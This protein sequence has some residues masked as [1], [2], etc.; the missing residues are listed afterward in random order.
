[1]AALGA[2]LCATPAF[3][4]SG[5]AGGPNTFTVAQAIATEQ[6]DPDPIWKGVLDRY[7]VEAQ[8]GDLTSAVERTE[9]PHFSVER[10]AVLFRGDT[11]RRELS[12][13]FDDGPHPAFTPQLLDVLRQYQVPATFFVVGEMA[14][15]APDLIRDEVA[16]GDEVGDHTYHHV[17]LIKVDGTDDAAEVAACGDVIQDITG[18]RPHLFRPPGGRL[19]SAALTAASAQGYTTVMWTDDPGDYASPGV[20]AIIC[21]TLHSARPGGILLLHDGI[22][23]TITALPDIITTLRAEGYRF[24]TVDQ[25]IRDRAA[26]MDRHDDAAVDVDRRTDSGL[27]PMAHTGLRHRAAVTAARLV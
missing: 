3:A 4:Y 6:R 24:V 8:Q 15:R 23:Q 17:S 12:L 25:M 27:Q 7:E 10:P 13:T 5:S 26:D 18:V 9:M 16:A 21:R 2:S 20:D 19:D 1:M 11:A 22:A 14:E